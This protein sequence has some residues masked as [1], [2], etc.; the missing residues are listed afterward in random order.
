MNS[1]RTIISRKKLYE[2]CYVPD[3]SD[4]HE[5]TCEIEISENAV[6]TIFD[7]IKKL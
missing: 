5:E 7:L 4:G 6:G 3:E 1:I 2:L